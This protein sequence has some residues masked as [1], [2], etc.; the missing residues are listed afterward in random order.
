MIRYFRS[1]GG[2]IVKYA[3]GISCIIMKVTYISY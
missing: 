2:Y 3:G 1:V